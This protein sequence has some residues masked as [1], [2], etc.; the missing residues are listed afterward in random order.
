MSG[1]LL[2]VAEA[3]KV[4]G[5][6]E[7]TLR[8]VLKQPGIQARLQAENRQGRGKYRYVLSIPPDVLADLRVLFLDG[9]QASQQAKQI[10]GMP[11]ANTGI[12]AASIASIYELRLTDKEVLLAEKDKRIAELIARAEFAEK[13]AARAQLLMSMSVDRMPADHIDNSAK[14]TPVGANIPKPFI[15]SLPNLIASIVFLIFTAVGSALIAS[16][17]HSLFPYRILSPFWFASVLILL[18]YALIKS[19]KGESTK[20]FQAR[21]SNLLRS[22]N[23]TFMYCLLWLFAYHYRSYLH[24]SYSYNIIN[25]FFGIFS[26]ILLISTLFYL[27]VLL[28]VTINIRKG[29][30]QDVPGAK[31]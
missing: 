10:T 16:Y 18:I 25:W 12:S 1:E 13:T 29:T 21:L 27:S 28:G 2:T 14:D 15:D 31:G 3:C 19:V 11:P 9:K 30:L 24:I 17:K 8:R 20:L 22:I 7:R 23:F 6:S 5:V 4:L 26:G